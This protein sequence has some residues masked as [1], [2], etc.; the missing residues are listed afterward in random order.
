MAPTAGIGEQ[1]DAERVAG[2]LSVTLTLVGP[3]LEHHDARAV[4]DSLSLDARTV[5]N[6]QVRRL[7]AAQNAA[8]DEWRTQRDI[9]CCTASHL[10]EHDDIRHKALKEEKPTCFGRIS[11]MCKDKHRA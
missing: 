3:H 2:E 1:S 7:L 10:S 9:K 6:E 8:G 5:K 11:Q 4:P